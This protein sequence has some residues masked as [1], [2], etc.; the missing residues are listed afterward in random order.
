MLS[1]VMERSGK[2]FLVTVGGTGGDKE[3]FWIKE[4]TH[5]LR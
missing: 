4:E 5:E 1:Q 3:V 2:T